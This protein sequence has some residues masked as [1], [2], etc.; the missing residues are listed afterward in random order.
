MFITM[1]TLACQS[2][3]KA[4]CDM[5]YVLVLYVEVLL[6]PHATLKLEDHTYELFAIACL[7]NLLLSYVPRCQSIPLQHKDA[8]CLG[9]SWL[10]GFYN[11]LC[12]HAVT[13]YMH[14]MTRAVWQKFTSVSKQ[15]AFFIFRVD[16]CVRTAMRKSNL[17]QKCLFTWMMPSPSTS[18]S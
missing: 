11:L 2:K 17:P 13:K 4:S 3:S 10:Y 18:N 1:L 15:H 5:S 9:A 14:D 6:A 8:Q 7:I 16:Y 12:T